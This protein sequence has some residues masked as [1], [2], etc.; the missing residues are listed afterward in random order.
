MIRGKFLHS[1]QHLWNGQVPLC[2]LYPLLKTGKRSITQPE[3][4]EPQP[5]RVLK[6]AVRTDKAVFAAY[7]HYPCGRARSG[8]FYL[9][10]VGISIV[11]KY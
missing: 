6:Q 1:D 7:S 10:T 9:A 11:P 8:I 2:P 4:T 3:P 5:L